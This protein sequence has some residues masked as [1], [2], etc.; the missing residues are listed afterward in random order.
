MKILQKQNIHS[1]TK[2]LLKFLETLLKPV[3]KRPKGLQNV[4]SVTKR[5]SPPNEHDLRQSG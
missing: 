5:E 4:S 3:S 2:G 1:L